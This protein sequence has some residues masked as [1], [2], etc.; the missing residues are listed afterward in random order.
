MFYWG[1]QHLDSVGMHGRLLGSERRRHCVSNNIPTKCALL[2]T[3]QTAG[4]RP[5]WKKPRNTWWDGMTPTSGVRVRYLS[6][7]RIN[8][9][10]QTPSVS[11]SSLYKELFQG[12][13][14]EIFSCWKVTTGNNLVRFYA[15]Q[16]A[17]CRAVL[18]CFA[19]WSPFIT[20]QVILPGNK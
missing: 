15:N 9:K 12:T 7:K 11:G 4:R 14:K 5:P 1:R 17:L 8:R 18:L 20:I 3:K 6:Q 16:A 2:P 19:S 10:Y 13:E